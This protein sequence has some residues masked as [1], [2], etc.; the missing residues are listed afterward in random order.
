MPMR[1]TI[2]RTRVVVLLTGAA[3]YAAT[4][5]GDDRTAPLT[6]REQAVQT[7]NRLA[8]GP[9]PGDIEHV[10]AVGTAAW[11]E[12]QIHPERLADAAVDA[13]LASLPTLGLSNAEL[14]ARFEEPLREA[15]KRLKAEKAADAA[16][17][18]PDTAGRLRD[19]VAPES[20]PRRI[21]E[22]LTQ[23][24]LIRA[25]GSERQLQEVLVDFWMNHFN[26][27]ANK[28]LD[29]IFIGSFERNA[30]R[31]WIWGRFEDLLLATAQSPAMLIYLDNARSAADAE[32]RP[33]GAIAL[34]RASATP[35]GPTGLNENYAREL[36]EL[37]TLGVDGGYTQHDVTELARVLTGW[38]VGLPRGAGAPEA[39]RRGGRFAAREP[40]PPGGFVF[41]ARLHDVGGKVVL[42]R[43]FPA[44]GGLA[45][46]EAALRM[47]AREPATAHHLAFELCQYLV[48]DAPPPALVERVTAR[49]LATGGDLRETVRAIVTSPEFFDPHN[50][51]AKIKTPFEYAVSAVRAMGGTTD[52]RALGRQIADM[53]EPLYLCQPPTGYADTAEAW[54]SSGALLA[55][56]NFSLALAQDRIPGTTVDVERVPAGAGT[57]QVLDGAIELVGTSVSADTLQTISKRLAEGVDEAPQPLLAGLLLGSPEFQK[58]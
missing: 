28:G 23:A 10:M 36:L 37:H 42:G 56:L 34:R 8:F 44:G 9:R 33:A 40:E 15:K 32:H 16:A 30:V 35:R 39:M 57:R 12:Q 54:V 5:S 14:V 46:G 24:R 29:R 11:I 55:R 27:Y 49:Y 18:A 38:S 3:L 20:R 22:D 19:L 50:Y 51:R 43:R 53:G 21:L 4:A 6:A 47:L 41:R 13:R 2:A 58:Q 1:H 26:V 31:P 7:L 45:E 25:V 52:G 48:A 17:D